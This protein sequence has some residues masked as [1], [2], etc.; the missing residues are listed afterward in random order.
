MHIYWEVEMERHVCEECGYEWT[1]YDS[2]HF[3]AC[4]LCGGEP[5]GAET[6]EPDMCQVRVFA[7][8]NGCNECELFWSKEEV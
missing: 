3:D 1:N 7:L 8:C 5:K 6:F 2:A 4:P